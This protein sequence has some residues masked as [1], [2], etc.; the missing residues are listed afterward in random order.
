MSI[1]PGG[2]SHPTGVG[3]FRLEVTA[4]PQM[5]AGPVMYCPRVQPAAMPRRAACQVCRCVSIRPGIT[6][7]PVASMISA[8]GWRRFRALR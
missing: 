1:P 3:V 4:Q 2:E 8:A 6:T 7:M 5:Q